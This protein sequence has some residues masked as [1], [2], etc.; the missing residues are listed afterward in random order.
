MKSKVL[1]DLLAKTPAE[2]KIFVELYAD[3]VVRVNQLIREKGYGSQKALAEKMGKKPSEIS[4]WLSGNHN[5]TLRSLAKLTAELGEPVI[6]VPKRHTFHLHSEKTVSMTVY[7]NE[8]AK[9][10]GAFRSA[11]SV[12]SPQSKSKV[13]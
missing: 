1:R 10:T 9:A 2:S 8:G 6:N 11:V 13:A 5:F 4:K 12:S 3:I 7:R